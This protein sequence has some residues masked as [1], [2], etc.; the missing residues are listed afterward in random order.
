MT[1]ES[2]SRQSSFYYV[3]WQVI[4]N[5]AEG[6]ALAAAKTPAKSN[7]LSPPLIIPLELQIKFYNLLILHYNFHAS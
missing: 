1:L 3:Q 5:F 6:I 4:L 7:L 2:I